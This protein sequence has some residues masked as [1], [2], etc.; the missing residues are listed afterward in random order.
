MVSHIDALT[1][2][3]IVGMFGGAIATGIHLSIRIGG[4]IA[5]IGIVEVQLAEI[6]AVLY[7]RFKEG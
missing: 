2:L 3:T 7:H 4:L 5:R 1:V 6:R